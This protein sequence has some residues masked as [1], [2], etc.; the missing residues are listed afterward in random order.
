MVD[1]A[2]KLGCRG[3]FADL[4]PNPVSVQL[5]RRSIQSLIDI[6]WNSPR[7]TFPRHWLSWHEVRYIARRAARSRPGNP[8]TNSNGVHVRLLQDIDEKFVQ[9]ST[10]WYSLF[11]WVLY[12]IIALLSQAAGSWF[13]TIRR[14]QDK[15]VGQ[16]SAPDSGSSR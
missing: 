9:P 10:S 1:D 11:Y 14:C 6:R 15:N 4:L 16:I 8:G 5:V 2:G 12:G 7:R 13:A 3:N